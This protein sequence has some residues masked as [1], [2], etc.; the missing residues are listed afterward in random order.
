MFFARAILS[1]LQVRTDS[2]DSPGVKPVA[3]VG[4]EGERSSD[5]IT[6]EFDVT[7]TYAQCQDQLY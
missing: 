7:I 2:G 1:C 3:K 5:E 6:E 4:F